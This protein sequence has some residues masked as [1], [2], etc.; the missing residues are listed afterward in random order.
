M[1]THM[2]SRRVQIYFFLEDDTIRV[3]EPK[4]KNSALP[5]GD[6]IRRHRIPR[7]SPADGTFYTLDDFN[8]GRE[9]SLYAKS[10]K[11]AVS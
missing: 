11:L 3:V 6:I 7:P 1:L 8:V 4:Q 5:Q 2:L 10:F 9:L